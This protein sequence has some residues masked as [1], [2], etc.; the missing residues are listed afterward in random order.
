[1]SSHPEIKSL[2][3]WIGFVSMRQAFNAT[4]GLIKSQT[5]VAT[6]GKSRRGSLWKGEAEFAAL[7]ELA[8]SPDAAA[9]VLHNALAAR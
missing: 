7:A 3:T 5:E 1:M 6:P 4:A 8:F 2:G 9:V